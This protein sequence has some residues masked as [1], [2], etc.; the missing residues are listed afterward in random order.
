MFI[1]KLL[2]EYLLLLPYSEQN[3]Y[4]SLPIVEEKYPALKTA[5]I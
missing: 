5:S 4:N 2:N 3:N 1:K